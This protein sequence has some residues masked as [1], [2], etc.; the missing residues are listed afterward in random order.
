MMIGKKS[1][2]SQI[3]ATDQDSFADKKFVTET[4]DD[5]GA[6][7]DGKGQVDSKNLKHLGVG[8][9][10]KKGFKPEAPNQDSFAYVHQEG[11]FELYGVFD[12]HGVCGHDVSNFVKEYLPKIFMSDPN[13]DTSN[14]S[15][16]LV[17]AVVRDLLAEPAAEKDAALD[18]WEYCI[19]V[20][21][22]LAVPGPE[23]SQAAAS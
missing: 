20:L 8:I 4:V 13:R 21:V 23:T 3:Q 9:A 16:M 5:K 19:A 15:F 1:P 11:D 12:G 17:S 10:C 14:F 18:E 6:V 2:R 22:G 7:T